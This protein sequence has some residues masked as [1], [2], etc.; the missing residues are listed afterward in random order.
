MPLVKALIA[1]DNFLVDNAVLPSYHVYMVCQKTANPVPMQTGNVLPPAAA[2][3]PTDDLEALT[4][5][6]RPK[7]SI[8]A[9]PNPYRPDPRG[10]GH[11]TLSWMSYATSK[12]EIHIGAPDGHIFAKSGPGSFSQETGHWVRDRIKFYLQ[13]VSG[14]LPL[15]PENTLGVVTVKAE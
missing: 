2:V 9:D 7:G 10:L 12:V 5:R 4:I 8:A 15:T 6:P 13:N 14:D 1:L 11:T 3:V